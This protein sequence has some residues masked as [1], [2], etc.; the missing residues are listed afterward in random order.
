M[1]D[2]MLILKFGHHY[3]VIIQYMVASIFLAWIEINFFRFAF[4]SY[5]WP[6]NGSK[7]QT[8]TGG[9]SNG[10]SALSIVQNSGIQGR[11]ATSGSSRE[12]TDDEDLEGETEMTDNMDPADAKRVRR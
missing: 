10:V 5:I 8:K 1:L 12:Q 7:F 4:F 6:G 9:G 11:S 3:M 2:H